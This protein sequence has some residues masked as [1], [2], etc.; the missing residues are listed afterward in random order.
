MPSQGLLGMLHLLLRRRLFHYPT[1]LVQEQ[2]CLFRIQE[3]QDRTNDPASCGTTLD[4]ANMDGEYSYTSPQF[5]GRTR[6][7][8]VGKQLILGAEEKL[9]FFQG[10]RVQQTF[11]PELN[12]ETRRTGHSNFH[13]HRSCTSLCVG[14]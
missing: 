6:S 1:T 14:I 7:H 13:Y 3:T 12:R 4:C 2:E 11:E 8:M 5:L 9:L 10:E